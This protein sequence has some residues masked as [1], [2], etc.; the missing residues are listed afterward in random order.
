MIGF[1][2]IG[3]HAVGEMILDATPPIT[4]PRASANM[5]SGGTSYANNQTELGADLLW[6]DGSLIAWDDDT[7]IGWEA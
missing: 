2:A 6:D 1:D 4:Y 5:S 7:L 3:R